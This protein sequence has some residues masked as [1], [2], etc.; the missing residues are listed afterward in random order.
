M[1]DD[2]SNLDRIDRAILNAYQGG[3]PVVA[4]PF[5][6]AAAALR[7]R[8]IDVSAE[9]L[10]DR[11]RRLDDDGVLSRFGALVNAEA[12]GGTAT[13]VAL[14]GPDDAEAFERVAETVNAHREVAHNYER[15]HD[16]LNM[17]FVLSVADADRVPAVL[18]TI[19][20]ETGCPTYDLPKRREFHVGARFP[21]DG[22]VADGIDL[23]GRAPDVEPSGR[24]T[25]TPDERDLVVALQ[26][27]F[28]A[29]RTPYADLA[30]GVG[31]STEWVLETIERFRRAGKVRRVGVVP[32]HYALGYTENPMTVWDVP[33]DRVGAVG[34]AVADLAF[35]T[36][37]YER[38]RHDGVWQ[39]NL[40]AMTHG[41]SADEAADRVDKVRE[42]VEAGGGD[43]AA[44]E[45]RSV[46]ILKKT[47]IRLN[48]RADAHTEHR[49]DATD[50]TAASPSGG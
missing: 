29:T 38:P 44:D 16:R 17:W 12:I 47:G 7:E 22:P 41:R 43:R 6:P 11:V 13:L 19:E 27:G 2:A 20:S 48:E 18:D 14:D 33:D 37:C 50:G 4:D 32:N 26:D 46:R 21:I 15:D 1:R 24:A 35:V 40:F 9:A 36:H 23:S 8:G 30:D 31:R 42:A 34:E 45:L 3:F 5:D 28:P 25:L 10:H 49:G 39:Y